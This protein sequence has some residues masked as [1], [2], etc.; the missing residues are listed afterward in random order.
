MRGENERA[1]VYKHVIEYGETLSWQPPAGATKFI[2]WTQPTVQTYDDHATPSDLVAAG[3]KPPAWTE[4]GG[5][6][7]TAD[8]E[9]DS[10]IEGAKRLTGYELDA[11][12]VTMTWRALLVI[13]QGALNEPVQIIAYAP[14][15]RAMRI[16]RYAVPAP[17][18]T[19]A[20]L[21]AAQERRFLE[22]LLAAR[23]SAAVTGGAKVRE[24]GEGER[25]EYESLAVLDRR[26]AEVRARIVWFDTAA[27]GN[28][29][30][31]QEFW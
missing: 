15:G 29:L 14:D 27:E 3:G 7:I 16:D 25:V 11:N 1:T 9:I 21:I 30:P 24:A 6:D 18:S 17:S 5:Y 31:R 20:G 22:H 19:E 4:A 26:I 10:G 2:V 23:E 8:A 13:A 12:G 28:A